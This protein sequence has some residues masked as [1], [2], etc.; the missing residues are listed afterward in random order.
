MGTHSKPHNWLFSN[1]GIN[2]KEDDFM[3]AH[4]YRPLVFN[5]LH[6][7]CYSNVKIDSWFYIFV[8]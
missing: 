8:G 5:H 4:I 1:R 3:L 7:Q 6:M 2:A